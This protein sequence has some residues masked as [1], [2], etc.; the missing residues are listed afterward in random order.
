MPGASAQ[1][2]AE[3]G[4]GRLEATTLASVIERNTDV[5]GLQE[6]VF[7]AKGT[8]VLNVNPATATQHK[9]SKFMSAPNDGCGDVANGTASHPMVCGSNMMRMPQISPETSWEKSATLC[10]LTHQTAD[11]TAD[12]I[13]TGGSSKQQAHTGNRD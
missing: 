13:L 2:A 11:P 8:E 6:N 1:T 10:S 5:I 9:M 12:R 3:S 4:A 7:F